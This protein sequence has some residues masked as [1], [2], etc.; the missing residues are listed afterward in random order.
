MIELV[1]LQDIDSTS[2]EAMRRLDAGATD[3][4]AILAQ[5]Q[6]A[7]RGRHGRTWIS[8]PGNLYMSAVIHPGIGLERAGELAFIAAV[9]VGRALADLHIGRDIRFKWPNDILIDDA[10]LCGILIEN[11]LQETQVETSVIGIGINVTFAP[12]DMAYPATS[13][14]ECG[15]G[16]EIVHL[17]QSILQ[18]L[19]VVRTLWSHEGFKPISAEWNRF[20][21]HKDRRVTVD[22]GKDRLTGILAGLSACGALRLV[23]DSGVMD[24]FSGSLI[25]QDVA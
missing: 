18:H 9:A 13:L 20:A 22:N 14:A 19:Q 8:P 12:G 24:I 3:E 17:A 25:Y 10:K 11:R 1:Q 23:T 6:S 16:I 7:G 2:S 5:S 21:W 15:S 4:F